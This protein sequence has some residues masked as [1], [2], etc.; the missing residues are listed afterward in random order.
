MAMGLVKRS[1][2][3]PTVMAQLVFTELPDL[4]LLTIVDFLPPE[5]T[6]RLSMTCRRL[7]DL[8]PEFLVMVGKDFSKYRG[9]GTGWGDITTYFEGPALRTVVKKLSVSVKGWEDQGW[10]NR[11]GELFVRLIRGSPGPV[12]AGSC[13]RGDKGTVIAE[14]RDFFGLAEHSE[15]SA[16]LNLRRDEEV[17]SRAQPGD[18]YRFMRRVGGGGGHTLTVRGF[19]AI[20]TLQEH[21]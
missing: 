7:Y 18:R 9:S 4:V 2:T 3:Q 20:A 12:A 16:S 15:T 6:A 11:K 5:D 14:R 8:L 17:V 1:P 10:G 19:R 21:S 13:G